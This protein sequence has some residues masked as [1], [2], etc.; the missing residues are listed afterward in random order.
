MTDQLPSQSGFISQEEHTISALFMDLEIIHNGTFN[1]IARAKRYGRWWV[2]KALKEVLRSDPTYTTLLYKEFDLLIAMQH[3]NIASGVSM[4]RVEGLGLCIVMEW[5]DGQ[6]LKDWLAEKHTRKER[7]RI[8]HQ[9]LFALEYIHGKQTAHR[10]LKPSNV[11]ITHN[12]QNVKLIDFGLSDTDDYAILKQPAGSPGYTAPE[13]EEN[14]VADIRNDIYSLGCILSNMKLGW[15]YT[16]IVRKCKAPTEWRYSNIDEVRRAFRRIQTVKLSV[17]AIFL[18]SIFIG[19]LAAALNRPTQPKDT[20]IYAIADSLQQDVQQNRT[21]ADSLQ[22]ELTRLKPQLDSTSNE[23][24]KR[25]NKDLR[26]KE[27]TVMGTRRNNEMAQCNL[28]KLTTYEEFSK[29]LHEK[30]AQLSDFCRTYHLQFTDI[31][32]TEAATIQTV[33][34]N[35]YRTCITPLVEKVEKAKR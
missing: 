33:L 30:A 9:L 13:Q 17:I 35:H 12:G 14:R 11:M 10:D 31:S 1:I 20:H 4:E 34:S 29:F 26:I 25:I 27:I 24:Q 32:E 5:I 18:L 2:L 3:A 23:L 16:P 28:D 21:V 8:V 7:L 19:T 6:T 22:E 15:D